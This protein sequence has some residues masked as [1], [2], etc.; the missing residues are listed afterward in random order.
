MAPRVKKAPPYL[1]VVEHYRRQI[2]DQE[3][4]PGDRLPTVEE[5]A[6]RHGLSR[7]TTEKVLRSLRAAGLVETSNRGSRI[8]Q[9]EQIILSPQGKLHS[10]HTTGRIDPMPVTARILRSHLIDAPTRVR[11]VMGISP[12]GKVIERRR[13]TIGP[14]G[15][16]VA[17]SS[18]FIHSRYARDVPELLAIDPLPGGTISAIARVSGRMPVRGYDL[19]GGGGASPEEAAELGVEFDRHMLRGRN[20]WLDANDQVV[21]Y[22]EFAVPVPFY[23]PYEYVI[24][25]VGL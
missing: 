19:V 15:K 7:A 16:P 5:M 18:S 13:L 9:H 25:G 6:E 1:Q 20:T 2:L 8:A 4:V 24:A 14:D 17:V 11:G 21:E 12:G 23:M 3:L 22:G 10:A